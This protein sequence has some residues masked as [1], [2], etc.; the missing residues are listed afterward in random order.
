MKIHESLDQLKATVKQ[1][2][3]MI[4]ATEK[5]IDVSMQAL[6]QQATPEQLQAIQVQV[7]G[8]KQ[9]FSKAKKGENVDAEIKIMTKTLNNGR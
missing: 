9:L 4:S 7:A 2:N 6:M 8:I 3:E 1:A 5:S